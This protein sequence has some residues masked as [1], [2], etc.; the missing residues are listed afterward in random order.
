M[1]MFHS[2]KDGSFSSMELRLLRDAHIE[3]YNIMKGIDKVIS[4]S[5]GKTKTIV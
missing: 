3:V 2:L 1:W 5:Q 4:H